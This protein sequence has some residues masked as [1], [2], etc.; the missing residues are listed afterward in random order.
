LEDRK[1]FLK[2]LRTTVTVV[3]LIG[4]PIAGGFTVFSREIITLVSG[5]GFLPASGA[6]V[7]VM[8]AAAV[9]FVNLV[10]LYAFV[11]MNRQKT[12]M[13]VSCVT[14]AANVLAN[15][16]LIPRFSYLGA[17]AALVLS[18][19]AGLLCGVLFIRRCVSE[20]SLSVFPRAAV[21]GGAMAAALFLPAGP[22]IRFPLAMAVFALAAC[23]A[24]LVTRDELLLLRSLV[25]KR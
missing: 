13:L 14:L 1:E 23:A 12:A 20:F 25:R 10:F 3:M 15:V 17:T 5:R 9:L 7:F 11:A 2:I 4:L 18:E 8:W 24:R 19:S 6:L 16:Y 22:L 21:A